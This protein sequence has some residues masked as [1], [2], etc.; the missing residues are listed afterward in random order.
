M[1]I[2]SVRTISVFKERKW[3]LLVR[4]KI[5]GV[6]GAWKDLTENVNKLATNLTTQVRKIANVTTAVE[7][8][9]FRGALHRKGEQCPYLT[10]RPFFKET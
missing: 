9:K 8:L 4:V 6:A 7:T 5:E 1:E 10:M 2:S 3:E